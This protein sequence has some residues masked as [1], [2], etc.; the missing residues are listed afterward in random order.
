MQISGVTIRH[1]DAMLSGAGGG[2]MLL[3]NTRLLLVDSVVR[4]SV[5]PAGGGIFGLNT[6]HLT[7]SGSSIELNTS[8]SSNGGG[9]DASGT[10]TITASTI[11]SNTAINSASGGGINIGAGGLLALRPHVF[12]VTPGKRD[13]THCAIQVGGNPSHSR[14]QRRDVLVR[15]LVKLH[16]GSVLV[17]ER[18]N[19]V[20]E[21]LECDLLLPA[22]VRLAGGVPAQR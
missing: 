22:R 19:G 4:D 17:L 21:A 12:V 20:V 8:D 13:H 6:S 2:F 11:L 3:A 7:I 14:Q 10:V 15:A 5:S 9:I 18:R 1:G 16:R